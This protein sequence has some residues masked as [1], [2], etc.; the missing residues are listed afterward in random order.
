[1]RAVSECLSKLSLPIERFYA[2]TD[3]TIVLSWLAVEDNCWS[4]FVANRVAKIQEIEFLE[5]SHVGTQDNPADIASRGIDPSKL[6]NCSL[7][8]SGP[9]WLTTGN[10]PA[11]L[12]PQG[13]SEEKKPR[14]RT[15]RTLATQFQ[16]S[17]DHS[18]DVIN[19]RE[20]NSF[21]K[22]L[23]TK[24]QVKPQSKLSKLYLFLHECILCVVD[25]LSQA[26]LPD[27]TMYP[28]L[29]PEKSELARLVILDAHHSTL[30]GGATQ[31]IAQIRTRFW[32]PGCRNQVRKLILNCV[33]C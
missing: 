4:T 17:N 3:S 22:T 15:I 6:K 31:T 16:E 11:Q 24:T 29:I 27:E 18:G 10:F 19:L 28:R 13:T 8:W 30:H 5:W 7:W 9:Q 14:A 26:D 32:I 12:Q 33:T 25:R 2:W 20:Q 23:E 21:R 1:M